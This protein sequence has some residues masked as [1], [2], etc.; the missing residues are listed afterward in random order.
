[1]SKRRIV[2]LNEV[3]TIQL[4][5]KIPLDYKSWL[6]DYDR[7]EHDEARSYQGLNAIDQGL[8]MAKKIQSFG[9][10]EA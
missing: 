7:P 3:L 5:R 2:F 8:E 4:G 1:M 10:E 6:T 9:V